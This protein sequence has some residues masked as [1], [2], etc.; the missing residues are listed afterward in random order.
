MTESGNYP[1]GAEF[2]KDAPYNQVDPEEREFEVTISQ[3]LSK[4]VTVLTSNYVEIEDYDENK[5]KCL[6]IDTSNTDWMEAYNESHKTPKELIKEFEN[7][8]DMFI[9]ALENNKEAG[10]KEM[11]KRF[12]YLKSECE[13][14]CIDE[15]EVVE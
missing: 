13:N 4:T 2:N 10:S 7:L 11:L 8:L 12:K 6:S 15:T 5:G 14:W 3:S 9:T 1:A